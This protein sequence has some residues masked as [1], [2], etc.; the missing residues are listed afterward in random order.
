[1]AMRLGNVSAVAARTPAGR[2]PREHSAAFVELFSRN[3]GRARRV[4]S[5]STS[6][7]ETLAAATAFSLTGK[8]IPVRSDSPPTLRLVASGSVTPSENARWR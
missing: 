8:S 5:G 1:M 2:S 7:P 6:R 3:G 4:P